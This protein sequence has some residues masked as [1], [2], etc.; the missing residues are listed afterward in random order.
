MAQAEMRARPSEECLVHTKLAVSDGYWWR[1]LLPSPD[2]W[3]QIEGFTLHCLNT[4][5]LSPYL[6]IHSAEVQ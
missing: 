2:F 1:A 6:L 4:P 5:G 3:F